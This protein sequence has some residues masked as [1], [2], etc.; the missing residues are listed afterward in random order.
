MQNRDI[1]VMSLFFFEEE[2]MRTLRVVRLQKMISEAAMS[3]QT[4]IS[5][6][7]LFQ[8]EMGEV[9]PNEAERQV[10]AGLLE[11]DDPEEFWPTVA[12]IRA[13]I[14][15]EAVKLT[16]RQVAEIYPQ[17]NVSTLR[18]WMSRLIQ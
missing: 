18:N 5:E 4:G 16:R 15:L 9:I 11:I 3:A 6:E 13:A 1:R 12:S 17:I 8:I 14:D 2:F 10:I 7:R